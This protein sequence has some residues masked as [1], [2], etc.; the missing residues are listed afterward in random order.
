MK[1]YDKSEEGREGRRE[2]GG[3]RR[4]EPTEDMVLL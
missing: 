4:E 3:M 1:S 2:R